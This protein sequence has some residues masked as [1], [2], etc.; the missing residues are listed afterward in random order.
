MAKPTTV[1]E[2]IASFPKDVQEKIQEIRAILKEVAPDAT[3][4]LKWG[5]PVFSEKR[6]LFAYAA[7]KDHL[8]FVPTGP[9]LKPFKKEL[10]AYKTGKDSVQFSYDKP[11]PKELIKKIATYRIKDVRENDAK[12]MY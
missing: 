4:S 7:F 9:S 10:E 11:L 6:N 1:D 3:E 2:Y 12:W 5:Q 8:N